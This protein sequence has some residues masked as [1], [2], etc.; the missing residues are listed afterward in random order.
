VLIKK[1][2]LNK[3]GK[4]LKEVKL[5]ALIKIRKKNC[6]ESMNLGMIYR[7]CPSLKSRAQLEERV[8]LNKFDRN[9]EIY[10]WPSTKF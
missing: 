4:I 6:F 2:N 1:P 3:R 9:K 8:D 10:C 5:C 7:F